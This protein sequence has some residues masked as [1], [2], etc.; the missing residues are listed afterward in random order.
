M[1]AFKVFQLSLF[2]VQLFNVA[3]NKTKRKLKF[4]ILLVSLHSTVQCTYLHTNKIRSKT[5]I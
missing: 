2:N 5:K 4:N 1:V 3:D